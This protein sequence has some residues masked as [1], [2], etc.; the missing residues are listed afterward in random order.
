MKVLKLQPS[1]SL[2]SARLKELLERRS[3]NFANELEKYIVHYMGVYKRWYNNNV[4]D[5]L[6]TQHQTVSHLALDYTVSHSP[7]FIYD[8]IPLSYARSHNNSYIK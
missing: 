3:Y 7:D 8:Y 1:T 2:T 6:Q 4:L 5:L